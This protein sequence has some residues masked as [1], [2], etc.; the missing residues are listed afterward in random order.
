MFSHPRALRLSLAAFLL[1]ALAI[2]AIGQ[3]KAPAPAPTAA[4]VD[5]SQV[6]H[7]AWLYKGSD[8]A[9]DPE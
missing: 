5:L 9:P 7:T 3:Q 8:I 4:D 1:S 6:D 2:P